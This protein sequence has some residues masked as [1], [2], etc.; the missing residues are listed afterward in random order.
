MERKVY[1]G[2]FH[3][4]GNDQWQHQMKQYASPFVPHMHS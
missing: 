1:E 2:N 4:P 3:F